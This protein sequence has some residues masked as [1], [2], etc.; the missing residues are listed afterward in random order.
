MNK[1]F[2][3]GL[4]IVCFTLCMLC[5]S[6]AQSLHLQGTVFN[7]ESNVPINLA[8]VRVGDIVTYT[9]KKGQ[10][11]IRIPDNGSKYLEIF[12]MGYDV[13]FASIQTEKPYY[14]PLQPVK[15]THSTEGLTGKEIMT[16]V[17]NKFHL[18]YEI[19]DQFM[20]SYYRE[21]VEKNNEEIQ[22]IAEGI[23]ELILS[24]NV[25]ESPSLIRPIKTRVKTINIVE[26][27]GVDIKSGHA[28]EMVE[29]SI[30][31]ERSF[32]REKN[33]WNYE[34]N[35]VG[36]EVHRN[37]KIYI[38]DFTPKNK[39]GYLA[40]RIYVDDY[41]DAIIRLEYTIFENLEFDTEVW[42]EEF[43]HHDLIY[44]LL[45]S[46]F[47]GVWQRGGAMYTFRSLV[48]NTEVIS[49]HDKTNLEGF[50][51]GHNFTFPITNH[52]E[53]TEAYWGEHNYIKLTDLELAQLK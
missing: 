31:H 15:P 37:E 28:T 10:F 3:T 39:K 46:S 43:Q 45:R 8:H 32:L 27:D 38:I 25:E 35:L 33:R 9:N 47:E 5:H 52:G 11:M 18:N 23:L 29:S 53:F 49:D 14:I 17:F 44:Y 12:H 26:H 50:Q 13:Y 21:V 4:L 34:Y 24:S 40:G 20:L 1:G 2:I 22:Y 48:V 19:H 42:I 7:K 41:S 51:Y 6:L 30:W 36:T 16:R